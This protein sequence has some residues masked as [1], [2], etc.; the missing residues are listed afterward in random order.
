MFIPRPRAVRKG[1]WEQQP[2]L[3]LQNQT[4]PW[5]GRSGLFLTPQ[6]L[7]PFVWA[8]LGSSGP[9]ELGEASWGP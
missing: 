3:A 9:G 1:S 5:L 2:V 7:S 4:G 6:H 8:A